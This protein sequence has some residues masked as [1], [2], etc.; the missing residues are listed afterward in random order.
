MRN[1]IDE[2]NAKAAQANEK[3]EKAQ[4]EA[5]HFKQ[6]YAQR[7]WHRISQEELNVGQERA[8]PRRGRLL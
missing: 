2:A 1:E 6:H 3:A 4:I 5:D 8:E 7:G